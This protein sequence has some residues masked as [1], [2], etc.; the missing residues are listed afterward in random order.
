MPPRAHVTSVEAIEEFRSS[1][2]VYVSKARPTLEEVSDEALRTRLWLEHDQRTRWETEV[3]RRTRTLENAQQA[4]F[5]AGI[6]NL[7]EASEGE[8]M[9]VQRARRALEEAEG[10]L[11]L[12]K[13][14]AREFQNR[15]EPL[16]RQ[17]DKLHTILSNDMLKAAAHLANVITALDAY[18]DVAPPDMSGTPAAAP[19]EAPAGEAPPGPAEAGSDGAS[20]GG[21][22]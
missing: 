4:L 8:R 2:I 14:W 9:A 5:S 13:Q 1:L 15:A 6:S 18:A 22:P 16:T 21:Q 7:G 10:K 17:L 3:R 19:T 20:K 12:V 11:K